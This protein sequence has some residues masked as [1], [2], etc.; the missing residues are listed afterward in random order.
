MRVKLLHVS[1]AECAQLWFRETIAR[2][3][4]HCGN[5][6]SSNVSCQSEFFFLMHFLLS[7]EPGQ[8]RAC[9]C[10]PIFRHD[11]AYSRAENENGTLAFFFIV[12]MLA[13]LP[14]LSTLWNTHSQM[15]STFLSPPIG[16]IQRHGDE[17]QDFALCQPFQG[18]FS[19]RAL[20]HA[21]QL[22]SL[23]MSKG[24]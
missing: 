12:F 7:T 24:K 3:K 6:P 5:I 4:M 10:H 22:G 11:S 18:M 19:C 16:T 14:F 20:M 15:I 1:E 2:D 17:R 23:E 8:K 13:P 9:M 21:P